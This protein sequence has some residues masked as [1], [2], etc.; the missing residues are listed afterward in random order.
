MPPAGVK[1]GEEAALA[2]LPQLRKL[3]KDAGIASGEKTDEAAPTPNGLK[4]SQQASP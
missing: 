4:S 2:A 3:L 1:A